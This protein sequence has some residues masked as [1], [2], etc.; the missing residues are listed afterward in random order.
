MSKSEKKSV[1]AEEPKLTPNTKS[2]KLLVGGNWKSNPPLAKVKELSETVLNKLK[3]D[4]SK[5][6][7]VI[8]PQAHHMTMLKELIDAPVSPR[9]GSPGPNKERA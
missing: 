6:E 5:V 4:S 9:S 7:V 2:R 3:F 1:K 8:A